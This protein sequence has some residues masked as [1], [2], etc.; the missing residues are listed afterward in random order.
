MTD[1]RH[2]NN[3]NGLVR[4][5]P[6][7]VD[8]FRWL[9]NDEREEIDVHDISDYLD[10]RPELNNEYPLA[11][12]NM[13]VTKAML[14]PYAKQLLEELELKGTST[15]KLIPNLNQKEKYV[16]DYRNLELYLFLGMRLTRI[17]R[18]MTFKQQLR[19]KTY[20]DFNTRK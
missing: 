20:I 13:K 18:V 14:S 12:E 7:P 4:S 9:D 2:A 17:H 3:L 6:F 10:Y 16:V 11:P 19:L 5:Q 15:E 1:V 8:G